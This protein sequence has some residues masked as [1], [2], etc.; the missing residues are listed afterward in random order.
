MS[1]LLKRMGHDVICVDNGK[2]GLETA[3]EQH[4][5]IDVWMCDIDM[6]IM[7]GDEAVG[8]LPSLMW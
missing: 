7:R 8:L 5:S 1:K 3:Q 4:D 6:P 2:D